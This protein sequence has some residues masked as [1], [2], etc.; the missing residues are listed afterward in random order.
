MSEGG[1]SYVSNE[2][3]H[4]RR[5]DQRRRQ[6]PLDGVDERLADM[7]LDR[8]QRDDDS[9]DGQ[10]PRR[11]PLPRTRC[12]TVDDEDAPRFRNHASDFGLGR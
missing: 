6:T 8:D 9:S 12:E 11:S 2:E 3:P 4:R 5:S 7:H 10:S 1:L